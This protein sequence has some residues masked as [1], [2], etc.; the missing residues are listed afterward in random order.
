MR[1]RTVTLSTCVENTAF[2]YFS[3]TAPKD[4]LHI[5]GEYDKSQIQSLSSQGSP[6]HTWRILRFNAYFLYFYRI[7]S[8]YVE[9][10]CSILIH[11]SVF[12]DH[13]H[14][15]GEYLLQHLLEVPNLGSPP[16]TWRI[17]SFFCSSGF[18]TRITSTYVENTFCDYAGRSKEED[19]LHIRGEYS[20]LL[21]IVGQHHRITS[22]YVENTFFCVR[23]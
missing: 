8:T 2:P 12:W 20:R 13:L 15:R 14:I 17:Q 16:H 21:M 23:Y 10:T 3:F 11:F 18:S 22:T 1:S 19:H 6:P 4:H 5:R 9:N 7:T